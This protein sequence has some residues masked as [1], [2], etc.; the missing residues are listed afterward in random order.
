MRPPRK[1]NKNRAPAG[2]SEGRFFTRY[3]RQ[4]SGEPGNPYPAANFFDLGPGESRGDGAEQAVDARA[5]N[6]PMTFKASRM[7][8]NNPIASSR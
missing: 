5:I 8:P 3:R 2:L 7:A 1:P 6:S 4:L